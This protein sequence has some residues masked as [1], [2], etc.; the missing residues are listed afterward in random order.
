MVT[1]AWEEQV[2]LADLAAVAGLFELHGSR[3]TLLFV[4]GDGEQPLARRRPAHA[5]Q[6]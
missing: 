3:A 5:P 1:D 4:D 6:Q 2:F